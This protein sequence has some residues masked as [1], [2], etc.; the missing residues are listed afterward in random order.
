LNGHGQG[1]TQQLEGV[2]ALLQ[3]LQLLRR[4]SGVLWFNPGLLFKTV[5]RYLSQAGDFT[6]VVFLIEI[7]ATFDT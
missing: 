2:N 7:S 6:P 3:H 4:S 1:H 5:Y